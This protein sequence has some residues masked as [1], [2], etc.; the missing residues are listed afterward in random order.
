MIFKYFE[1][2]WYF[3]DL[4]YVDYSMIFIRCYYKILLSSWEIIV[5]KVAI[6]WYNNVISI[7]DVTHLILGTE[8]GM[9]SHSLVTLEGCNLLWH[10]SFSG[11]LFLVHP[12]WFSLPV[13][14]EVWQ[15]EAQLRAGNKANQQGRLIFEQSHSSKKESMENHFFPQSTLILHIRGLFEE[16]LSM[17]NCG[18]TLEREKN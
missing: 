4:K 5:T 11:F 3:D 14:L 16:Y 10:P 2:I 15:H 7:D 17:K 12:I 13:W 9:L 8:N 1:F 6:F 18:T